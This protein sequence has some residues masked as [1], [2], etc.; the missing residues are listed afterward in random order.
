MPGKICM[1]EKRENQAGV[2]ET[3]GHTSGLS[4][5]VVSR[6]STRTS[7]T[8]LSFC[9]E[10]RLMIVP[11]LKIKTCALYYSTVQLLFDCSLIMHNSL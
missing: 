10:P 9:S 11:S 3:T 7:L 8:A 2:E 6:H 5:R 1:P 4:L